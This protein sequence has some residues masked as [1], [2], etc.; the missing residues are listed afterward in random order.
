MDKRTGRFHRGRSIC[1]IEFEAQKVKF[2]SY[3]IYFKVYSK[4]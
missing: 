3:L 1:E 2:N 4:I